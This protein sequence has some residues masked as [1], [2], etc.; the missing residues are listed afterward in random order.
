MK[1]AAHQ[2][3]DINFLAIQER[4][5]RSMSSARSMR[6]G[7]QEERTATQLLNDQIARLFVCFNARG[8]GERLDQR[9]RVPVSQI[10]EVN[11]VRIVKI[12]A[13]R[14]SKRRNL[15]AHRG[16][17]GRFIPANKC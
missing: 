4:R 16:D 15:S 13:S 14:M 7:G 8:S 11:D 3:I 17:Y 5:K 1:S 2:L 12:R 10:V 9:V 6:E